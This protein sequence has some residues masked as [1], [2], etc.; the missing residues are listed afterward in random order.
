MSSD[1]G[2]EQG[3]ERKK[4]AGIVVESS[5]SPSLS[6]NSS[7]KATKGT[8]T[9][10]IEREKKKRVPKRQRE[11]LQQVGSNEEKRTRVATSYGTL[12]EAAHLG[13]RKFL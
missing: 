1:D 6:S 7:T 13:G 9:T 12:S 11:E 4:N 10:D 3:I 2:G 5:S 8:S